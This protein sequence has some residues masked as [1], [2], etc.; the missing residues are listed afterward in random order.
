MRDNGI[1]YGFHRDALAETNL[2]VLSP[3]IRSF[4]DKHPELLHKEADVSWLFDS[5]NAES[6]QTEE[7][8]ESLVR[9]GPIRLRKR[10]N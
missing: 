9:E 8:E 4:I 3:R 2:R 10:I 7:D 5:P 1:E 6:T